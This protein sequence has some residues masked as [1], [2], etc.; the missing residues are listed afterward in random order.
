M[1]GWE[2]AMLSPQKNIIS[3]AVSCIGR[4]FR[5]W[6][7]LFFLQAGG[8]GD[9]GSSV[10]II[11]MSMRSSALKVP[12][13]TRRWRVSLQIYADV[14]HPPNEYMAI[15]TPSAPHIVRMVD[16]NFRD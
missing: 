15:S 16:K 1:L 12:L 13:K 9:M 8:Y 3:I 4:K 5:V 2:G 11:S 6:N 14:I 7:D 10:R